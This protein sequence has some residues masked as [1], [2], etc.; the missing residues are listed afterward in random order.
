[1]EANLEFHGQI[2]AMTRNPVVRVLTEAL[3][4]LILSASHG[5]R[6][7]LEDRQASVA[8]HRVI[9]DRIA[10]GDARAAERAHR[11]HLVDSVYVRSGA[12]EAAGWG[13]Q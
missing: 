7:T 12:V 1:L 9:V 3:R 6:Y 5:A 4:D 10:R 11:N 2:A 8:Q 13:A